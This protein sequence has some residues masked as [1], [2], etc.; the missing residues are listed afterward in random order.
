MGIGVIKA[1]AGG[2]H[3]L[4]LTDQGDVYSFGRHDDGQLGR[5]TTDT[6]NPTALP[7][8][9]DFHGDPII[10]GV[11]AGSRHSSAVTDVGGVF[12]WGSNSLGQLGVPS[13]ESPVALLDAGVAKIGWVFAGHSSDTT[14]LGLCDD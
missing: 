3:S 13:T 8:V 6:D 5:E 7:G 14:L 2:W 12:V 1:C 10:T 4:V 11:A 9:I